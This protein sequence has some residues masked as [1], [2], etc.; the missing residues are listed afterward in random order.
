MFEGWTNALLHHG[1]QAGLHE[2]AMRL[3]QDA[4]VPL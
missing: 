2:M 3:C 1:F 4:K